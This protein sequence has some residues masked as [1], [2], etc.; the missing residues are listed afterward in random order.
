MAMRQNKPTVVYDGQCPFCIRQIERF[1]SLDKN[2]CFEYVARQTPGLE[3]R[4]PILASSDFNSGMRLIWPAG[5]VEVGADAVYQICKRLPRL[6]YAA[7]LYCLPGIKQIG[8]MVYAWIAA[9][10]QRLGRD[11]ANGQCQDSAVRAG[12]NQADRTD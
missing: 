4:F 6:R 8:R 2:G 5:R 12:Q 11:C 3:E 7:W 1:Q 9:N 10:R